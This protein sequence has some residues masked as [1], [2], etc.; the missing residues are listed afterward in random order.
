MIKLPTKFGDLYVDLWFGKDDK[1][2]V[3]DSEKRYLNYIERATILEAAEIAATTPAH[4]LLDFYHRLKCC[5]SLDSFLR[6]AVENTY[7][8]AAKDWEVIASYLRH[9]SID[10]YDTPESL[11]TNEWVNKIGDYYIVVE[12]A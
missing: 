5:N 2:R 9:F 1:L 4:A 7:R 8:V 12:E 10:E 6:K 11:L 3:Y